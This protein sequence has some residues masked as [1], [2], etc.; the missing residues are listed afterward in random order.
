VVHRGDVARNDRRIR[1]RVP[2]TS[3]ARTMLDL[4]SMLDDEALEGV[5][6][7]FFHRGVTTP[8]AVQRCLDAAGGTGRPGS[9]LLRAHLAD[10]DEAPLER[11]LEQTIWRILRSAGLR[12]VRQY[13]VRC[14]RRKYRLDFAWPIFKVAV[15]GQGFAAHGGRLAHARDNRRLADLVAAGWRVIPVTWES[16]SD[17]PHRVVERVRSA[18][19]A[20][21]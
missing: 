1:N 16:A 11:R 2:V 8:F 5:A 4:S 20:A 10:R 12:P 17:E 3:P 9:R 6:E 15:E 21:A 19:V 7:D 14:G 13:E 18:L